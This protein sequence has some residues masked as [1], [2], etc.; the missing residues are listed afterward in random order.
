[1]TLGIT[2]VHAVEVASKERRFLAALAGADLDDD[3]LLIQRIL[4]HEQLANALGDLPFRF[5]GGTDVL[6]REIA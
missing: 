1:M 3:A 6:E 5:V 4:R 2:R